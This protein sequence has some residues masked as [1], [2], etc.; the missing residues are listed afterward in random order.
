MNVPGFRGLAVW[1]VLKGAGTEFFADRMPTYAA[2]LAYRALFALFPFVIFLI[3]LVGFLDLPQLFDW[4]REQASFVVPADSMTQVNRAIDE[5]QTPQGG[6]LSLGIAVAL[7]SASAGVVALMDALN[8]AYDVEEARAFWKRTL[9]SI[10]YTVALAGMLLIAAGLMV[11]GPQVAEWLAQ[12]IG[13]KQLVV[14]LWTW[15]RLP[16][17]VLL[18]ILVVAIVYYF[19][20][21]VRQRFRLLT[22]GAVLAVIAWIVGSLAFALYVTRFGNYSATY[23]SLGAIV[24][25]LLYF[26]ISA[27]VLLFGAEINAE[28]EQ[29]AP[30]AGDATPAAVPGE[31]AAEKMPERRERPRVTAPVQGFQRSGPGRS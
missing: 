10:V 28:I 15:L 5:L 29:R 18:M 13:L 7:W 21:N 16:V 17:A 6:L 30:R 14:T 26:Y 31:S 24:V 27:T 3:A 11:I 19:A 9:L 20:P 4:L 23:G 12:R 25:L 22:P 2:A 8:E 1:P